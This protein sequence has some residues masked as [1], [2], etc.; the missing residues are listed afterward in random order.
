MFREIRASWLVRTS[1][2]YFNKA[3]A[4]RHTSALSRYNAH[5]IRHQ[6][7]CE[8]FTMLFVS[9]LVIPGGLNATSYCGPPLFTTVCCSFPGV[10]VDA[11]RL[12]SLK[13]SC[14][15]P[16]AFKEFP[17]HDVLW[18]ATRIHHPDVCG[19]AT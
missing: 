12:T 3:R 16:R 17:V 13:R 10:G 15:R 5:T 19:L 8:Q 14:G 11:C 2:L 1:S 6:D 4:L 18:N 9:E 7:E